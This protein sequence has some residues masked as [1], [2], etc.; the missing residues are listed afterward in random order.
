LGAAQN[1]VHNSKIEGPQRC[2]EGFR[3][4]FAEWRVLGV[5]G[6]LEFWIM[7]TLQNS[8]GAVVSRDA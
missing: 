4:A 7:R 1:R 6:V 2:Q 5:L 3:A 8:V